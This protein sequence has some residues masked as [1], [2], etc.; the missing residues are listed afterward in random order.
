MYK[1]IGA[2]G[3][4]YGPISAEQLRQWIAEGRANMQ[5]R[6]Q[7][8][9]AM[10]WTTIGSL[11]EFSAAQFTPPPP[12]PPSAPGVLNAPGG[13]TPVPANTDAVTAPAVALICLA[14]LGFLLQGANL[15]MA[16]VGFRGPSAPNLPSWVAAMQSPGIGLISAAFAFLMSGLVLFG[17]LKMKRLENYSLA[18]SVSIIAMIP[19]I[20]PCCLIGLPIG[21]WALVVLAKPEVKS[22]FH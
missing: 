2:D 16:L 18:M 22:A 7:P 4:E 9:G 8:E 3:N 11:P 15:V 10:E 21:I 5:T 13:Y 17:A 20:S 19:C 14:C 6:V 12:P 1:I